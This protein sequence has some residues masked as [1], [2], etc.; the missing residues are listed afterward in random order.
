MLGHR[1]AFAHKS[2]EQESIEQEVLL[3]LVLPTGES[4]CKFVR[5]HNNAIHTHYP[6]SHH[7]AAEAQSE[8]KVIE[9]EGGKQQDRRNAYSRLRPDDGTQCPA[10]GHLA[11]P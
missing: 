9:K 5:I 11:E 3:T 6:P 2:G 1:A 7:P 4:R 8:D 10:S